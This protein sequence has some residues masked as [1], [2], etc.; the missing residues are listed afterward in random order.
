MKINVFNIIKIDLLLFF[1]F[2]LIVS[3]F[4]FYKLA[5]LFIIPILILAYY[6]VI[7]KQD[8][9]TVLILMLIS[10]CAMGFFLPGNIFSFNI[11]N[12]LC[13]YL[14]L[15][16]FLRM[17]APKLR[18]LNLKIVLSFKFTLLYVVV[19]LFLCLPNLYYSI[20][21]FSQEVLPII[22]FCI[23]IV[24]TEHVKI[25]FDLLLNF[26]RYSFL[27]VLLVYLLP[28]FT[29]NALHLFHN[30]II[31][32]EGIEIMPMF[33]GNKI[34]RNS[35]FVFDFRMLGQLACLYFLI[36]YYKGF[37]K[38]YL[39]VLLLSAV[40]LTTFSRGPLIILAL[41]FIAVYG[42]HK[43]TKLKIVLASLSVIVA[44]CLL[45][46]FTP[47]KGV[48]HF[49]DSFNP[50]S[51]NNAIQ[52]RANFSSYAIAKFRDN[53]MGGGVGSL[54]S[55]NA[56]NKIDFG[57]EDQSHTKRLFYYQVVDAY[58]ALTLGEKG[59][60]GF[61][62]FFL[63]CVE[64]FFYRKNLVSLFFLLGLFINLIG[65]DI[66]KQGFFYFVLLIIYYELSRRDLI[67]NKTTPSLE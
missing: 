26:F 47:N 17:K 27:A 25:N 66:P 9:A 6:N 39:D 61:I 4:T 15:L 7:I 40:A 43:I 63:S 21:E 20:T 16:L 42:V 1:V 37:K 32:K 65:T 44:F 22:L 57:Y 45:I 48:K 49:I 60:L 50:L 19:L 34:P 18:T 11:L 51:K 33:V 62:L 55:P 53:P 12:I 52:Q 35:G 36:L 5:P 10:R 29:E 30:P 8:F 13:N 14:P 41:I 38:K 31:F 67:N 24:F 54:S 56:D 64:I 2:C 59:V 46:I 23:L 3:N 58:W 28:N